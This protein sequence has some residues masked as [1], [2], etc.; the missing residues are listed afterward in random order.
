MDASPERAVEQEALIRSGVDGAVVLQT[1]AGIEAL[2]CSGQSET[3]IYDEVPRGL[4]PKPTLS[5][6]TRS[7]HAIDATV[8]L[9]YL[10]TGFD[11]Q[12]NYVATLSPAGDKLDLFAWLT[13]ANGDETSFAGAPSAAT[14]GHDR[15]ADAGTG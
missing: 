5:V 4:S 14:G 15:A 13:L 12:A 11:W 9:S 10:A 6:L 7:S 2:R 8:T 1:E 3:L